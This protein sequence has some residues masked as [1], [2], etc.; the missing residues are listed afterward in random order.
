L[1]GRGVAAYGASA[2]LLTHLLFGV[3]AGL[4]AYGVCRAVGS[5][6]R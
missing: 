3:L 4:V 5:R 2:T 6:S 1:P